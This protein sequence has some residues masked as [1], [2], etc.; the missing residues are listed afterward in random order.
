MKHPCLGVFSLLQKKQKHGRLTNK[1]T[2]DNTNNSEVCKG[3]NK[4][5]YHSFLKK[6][7]S[8]ESDDCMWTTTTCNQ[9]FPGQSIE[10]FKANIAN[11][12]CAIF[13]LF[14]PVKNWRLSNRLPLH[15]Y[16]LYRS[17]VPMLDLTIIVDQ[18]LSAWRNIKQD[19]L[20]MSCALD[21]PWRLQMFH[22]VLVTLMMLQM[23]IF[24]SHPPH[25]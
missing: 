12:T 2:P 3:W 9:I 24:L 5:K 18:A 6:A 22:W 15:L 19:W 8:F 14:Q 25:W 11:R 13:N 23:L 16:W 20:L 4:S 7:L 17:T 1:F 21:W 10:L